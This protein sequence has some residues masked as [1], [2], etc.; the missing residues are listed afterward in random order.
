MITNLSNPRAAYLPPLSTVGAPPP[1]ALNGG[2]RFEQSVEGAS[3]ASRLCWE[4][5]GKTEPVQYNVPGPIK[6]KF[7]VGFKSHGECL[8]HIEENVSMDLADGEIVV[9]LRYIASEEPTFSHVPSNSCWKDEP[10]GFRREAQMENRKNLYF[11]KRIRNG[12]RLGDYRPGYD[13]EMPET[14]DLPQAELQ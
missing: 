1:F 2:Q 13:L 3:E 14:M 8:R 6:T 11:P 12:R 4:L 5:R 10:G 9:P 7:G